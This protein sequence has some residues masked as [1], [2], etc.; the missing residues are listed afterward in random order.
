MTPEEIQAEIDKRVNAIKL[1]PPWKLYVGGAVLLLV[2]IYLGWMIWD[3]KRPGPKPGDIAISV[4]EPKVIQNMQR[5]RIITNTYYIKDK[6]EA[7]VKLGFPATEASNPK[8]QLLTAAGIAA[9]K[10]GA[11]V[12]TFVNVSTGKPRTDIKYKE[13]PWFAFKRDLAVGVGTGVSTQGTTYAGRVRL[14]V[15]QIKEVTISPEI[16][17]NYA[18][19]RET[20]VESRAMI[21]AEWRP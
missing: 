4:P 11:T 7:L 1:A 8:E 2:I 14:D 12:A 21:W 5:E 18:D 3:I 17:L 20:P 19:R 16:E 15:M 6:E 9:N 10:Y 13:A